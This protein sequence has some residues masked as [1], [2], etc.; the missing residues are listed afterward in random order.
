VCIAIISRRMQ[1]THCNALQHLARVFIPFALC[2]C[3]V[4]TRQHSATRR[5]AL[6]RAATRCNALQRAATRCNML[7]YDTLQHT[8]THCNSLQ[9]TTH[10]MITSTISLCVVRML[11]HTATRCN[12]LDYDTP[13]HTAT[14][15]NT[16]R[17]TA[18]HCKCHHPVRARSLCQVCAA[19]HCKTLEYNTLQHPAPHCN[20]LYM[21][22]PL[23]PFSACHVHVAT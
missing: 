8:A 17:H 21:S 22:S 13:Q 12:T 11:Q 5:N 9:L 15:C 19:T 18:T 7:G 16:L 3:F 20:T 23:P 4:R 10:V 14:H 1:C 2:L 6:Q